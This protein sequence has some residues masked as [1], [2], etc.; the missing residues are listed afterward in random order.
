MIIYEFIIILHI[1]INNSKIFSE[2][3]FCFDIIIFIIYNIFDNIIYFNIIKYIY[4]NEYI[5]IN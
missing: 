3:D 1:H 4:K 5:F 2:F